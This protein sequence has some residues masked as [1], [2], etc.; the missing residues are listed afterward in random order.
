MSV[1]R[2][3]EGN[4][5]GA[6]PVSW[7]AAVVDE[8]GQLVNSVSGH[9][10]AISSIEELAREG[11]ATPTPDMPLPTDVP[12]H[13]LQVVAIDTAERFSDLLCV[14][15]GKAGGLV[16][17]AQR[18]GHQ[19]YVFDSA[20]SRK[21]YSN[22]RIDVLLN[23]LLYALPPLQGPDTDR[24]LDMA[25]ALD[26]RHPAVHAVRCYYACDEYAEQVARASVEPQGEGEFEALL[27]ALTTVGDDYS[28]SY[29]GGIA[30]GGGL[31]VDAASRTLRNLRALHDQS[32]SRLA[33]HYSF[34]DAKPPAP[35]FREMKAASATLVFAADIEERSLGEK[36]S[37]V[38]ELR[39]LES[40][41]RGQQPSWLPRTEQL[42][43]AILAVT[44]PSPDT[45][46]RHRRGH[47][48]YEHVRPSSGEVEDVDLAS[49]EV[50]V[51]GVQ[52]GIID[53]ASRIEATI[54]PTR[55]LTVSAIDDGAGEVPSGAKLLPRT[56]DVLFRPTS[57]VLERRVDAKR[58]ERF[59]LKG[60][61]WLGVGSSET[62]RA[63]P[64]SIVKGAFLV[65]IEL[66]VERPQENL[67]RVGD[68]SYEGL[69]HRQLEA[70][71]K[72]VRWWA[73]Q[74]KRLELTFAQLELGRWLPPAKPPK[75]T[76]L[77]RLLV[78]LHGLGGAAHQSLAVAKVNEIFDTN[79][80]VNNTRREVLRNPDKVEFGEGEEPILRLTSIGKAYAR[81]WSAISTTPEL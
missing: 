63:I 71:K 34:L 48:E 3:F 51:F 69:R 53:N 70:S 68:E 61:E 37:R 1:V 81:V 64:S 13:G 25:L 62:V 60:F 11:F 76:A 23:R 32:A 27:D 78:A 36:L 79:V 14:D 26:P 12:I 4:V 52:T 47:S 72:L 58:R 55:V 22:H 24:L 66:R 74:C 77:N 65:D 50:S 7:G 38:L 28:I 73:E 41:L 29:E 80:R 6:I 46:V 54:F 43:S 59:L 45:R 57:F 40:L 56:D 39:L 10:S 75:I 19:Y 49:D 42:A 20:R 21:R 33:A 17:H 44:R 31:D 35:R 18:K 30:A 8:D 2:G 67:L 9:A 16:A 5:G 15:T